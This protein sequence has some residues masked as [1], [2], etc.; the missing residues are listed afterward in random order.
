MQ[1][2]MTPLFE[3]LMFFGNLTKITSEMKKTRKTKTYMNLFVYTWM[4]LT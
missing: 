4:A 3:M 1:T 2:N